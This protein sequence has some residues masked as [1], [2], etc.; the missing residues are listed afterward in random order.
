MWEVSDTVAIMTPP[1]RRAAGP[2]TG[3]PDVDPA[4][5]LHLVTGPEDLLAERAVDRVVAAARAGDPSVQVVQV[6]PAGYVSGDL[7]AHASPSLFGEGTVLVLRALE[8][9]PDELLEDAKA[10]VL[11]PEPDVVLVLRHRSGQ[12]GKGLLDAAKKAGA[13]V[14]DCPKITSDA[15]K[16]T[17]VQ[18]EF[19]RAGRRIAPEAVVALV[20]ALGQDVRELASGCTQLM[21]DTMPPDGAPQDAETVELDV[22]ERYYGDRVEATGF[23]VADAAIAGQTDQAL[24]LLRHALSSGV[25]PVPIVAVLALGLRSL[26]K[27]SSSSV[28]GMR[29][30][31][32]ARDL[33]MAPWQVDK[34]RRQLRAWTPSGLSDAIQ[35]VAAADL[36]VK[37]GLP[38]KGRRAGDPVYAVEKA[39][40]EIGA[41]RRRTA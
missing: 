27:V 13:G 28:G 37:G 30:A 18:G 40:L 32:V 6:E 31:D 19:R 38:I 3:Q 21:A 22:V 12:R 4:G 7:A 14:H 20:E 15:D 36:A 5:P 25:D 29:S 11:A 23:K 9:A 34:A 41:A 2:S 16:T 17:F 24:G 26:A 35:A 39:V 8:D 1:A 33:G 10:L